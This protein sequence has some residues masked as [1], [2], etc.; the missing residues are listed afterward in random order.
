MEFSPNIP[1]SNTQLE[2]SAPTPTSTLKVDFSWKKFKIGITTEDEEPMYTVDVKMFKA[3]HLIFRSATTDA[4]I[5]TGSIHTFSI[6][7]SCE[8]HGSHP[9][10]KVK[11]MR[12][13]QTVYSYP[14]YAYSSAATNIDNNNASNPVTMTWTATCGLKTWKF[15]CLDEQQLPVAKLS[16]NEWA[17]KKVGK[18]EFLGSATTDAM[19]DEIVVT[20]LTL[21]YCMLVRSS[22]LIAF[23]TAVV[24]RPGHDKKDAKPVSDL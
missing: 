3:P 2:T 19:R 14:S 22:S 4:T 16:V 9:P 12:R 13:F 11:A 24:S 21:F 1:N 10:F 20:G 23:F 8:L 7:A 18:F 15:I 17:V 6:D 5:G